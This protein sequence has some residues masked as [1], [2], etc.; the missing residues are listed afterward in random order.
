MVANFKHI[1][2]FLPEENV[3]NHQYRY[4]NN[5]VQDFTD[6]VRER[7]IPLPH[8]VLVHLQSLPSLFPKLERIDTSV[9]CEAAAELVDAA[10]TAADLKRDVAF[11]L[12][13]GGS[14]SGSAVLW[15]IAFYCHFL[16]D[17]S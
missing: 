4:T 14:G 17:H 15:Q 12:I 2:N 3:Y 6:H 13:T 16:C 8:L 5:S 10:D 9:Q 7:E 1:N 11:H